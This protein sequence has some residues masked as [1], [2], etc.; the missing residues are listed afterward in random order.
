M[1]TEPSIII[2]DEENSEESVY[3]TIQEN[4][5]VLSVN[6]KVGFVVLNKSDI[7][8]SDVENLS[9]TGVSGSLQSQIDSLD[10]N[11]AS[12]ADLSGVSGQL[13]S[14]GA[15][16]LETIQNLSGYVNISDSGLS[17][18]ISSLSGSLDSTG[19]YL[20]Y[21]IDSLI[22]G[23]GNFNDLFYLKS[24]PAGYLT[25]FNSGDYVLKN[26]TGQ[27]YASNNP[28]EFITLAALSPY[29]TGFA[30]GDYVQKGET[31]IF[32]TSGSLYQS[33][34]DLSQLINTASGDLQ[35][36]INNLDSGY[37]TD[38]QLT[39][40]SGF[41]AQNLE[42]TG[43]NLQNQINN[44]D[45][46]YDVLSG[47][48]ESS[49]SNLINLITGVSGGLQG[50]I[51]GLSSSGF[52]T[53]FNSGDYVL[54]GETGVF[55]SSYDL[56]QTGGFLFNMITGSSGALQSQIYNSGFNLSQKID[57]LS[58]SAVLLYGNQSVEGVKRF[59]DPTY[60]RDLY[61]TGT[62]TIVNTVN[63]NVGSNYL[64]L[65]ATGGAI[66]A[67][68]FIVTGSNLT[69][70]N[71]VGAIIGYDVPL[72]NW[73]FGLGTRGGDLS[74]LNVIA[75]LRDLLSLSGFANGYFYPNNNPSGFLSSLSGHN[76]SELTNDS[77]YITGIYSGDF[78]TKDNP[79]GY[80]TTGQLNSTGNAI[81]SY[82]SGLSGHFESGNSSNNSF[83]V[84]KTGDQTISG[85]KTFK[86]QI[87]LSGL[88]FDLL[89]GAGL[90]A[91]GEGKVF[92]DSDS[93]T[94]C[95]YND[96]SEVTVN[97]GQEHIVRVSNGWTGTITNGMVV[98]VSGALGNRPKIFPATALHT[99]S[100]SHD[101]L[102]VATQEITNQGYVTL[103]GL[104]NGLNTDGYT[105]GDT[106]YLSTGLYGDYS[107]SMP[108]APN[109]KVKVGIVTRSHLNQGQIFVKISQAE[110]LNDLNDVKL[111]NLQSGDFLRYH[112]SSG[113]WY[114]GQMDLSNYATTGNLA[115]TGVNLQQQLNDMKILAIAY[116]IAL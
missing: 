23:T 111:D 22:S 110:H 26:E 21:Q 30:S 48:L 28:L 17:G 53:G 36:Q 64:L 38:T 91:W 8:L 56:N 4:C 5:R 61:V 51:N 115:A 69:G 67:G 6:G 13:V 107:T 35:G 24:N 34:Y 101:I 20:L 63:T 108:P 76:V 44:L 57:S 96:S 18:L 16:L 11:Y 72:N 106:L 27:F 10:L 40:L 104:V 7:G 58:G 62:Q 32:A 45:S 93:H 85:E 65:N 81:Y 94:L 12:D 82:I 15:N 39:G 77:G 31:G 89:T 66:D 33:G 90:P 112:D 75:S 74:G 42:Q 116:A 19:S 103:Q 80:A 78:Y 1:P 86:N 114:N 55:A 37:A 60:I 43:L 98:Y 95:Y 109:H 88:K 68:L 49:G 52:L 99:L 79:S 102:G 41:F 54:K 83:I 2:V 3:I 100:D 14:S 47:N 9:I 25:G 92:Y 29:M 73:V 59:N 46:G 71:D 84:Y 70:I 87:D 113:I 97:V 105:V 50:Q